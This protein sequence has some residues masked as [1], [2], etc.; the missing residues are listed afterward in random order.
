VL[1][2]CLLLAAGQT[3]AAADLTQAPLRVYGPG[4]PHEVLLECAARYRELHGRAVEV[5]KGGPGRL[6]RLAPQ[7]GDLYY[8]GAEFMLE[9]FDRR[10][11][12]VLDLQTVELLYPRRV[13]IIVRKGNPLGIRGLEDLGRDGIRVMKASR[14]SMHE[15][16]GRT[17]AA[18]R[19]GFLEPYSGRDALKEW[20]S[21]RG[22]DAWI[23][24]KSWHTIIAADA[25]FVEI[26]DDGAL[27]F[28]PVA[29]TTRTS[30]RQ[31]AERFIA[32]LKSREAARIFKEHGWE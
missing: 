18:G 23:T 13:G 8:G 10:N 22:I 14:E 30:N 20:R 3:R 27:R 21:D 1:I 17:P 16:H 31:E 25:D 5:L 6:D 32:F 28:T 11:P 19:S 29:I 12:G 9:D 15:F 4:G 2:A 24:Y 7:D 26:P